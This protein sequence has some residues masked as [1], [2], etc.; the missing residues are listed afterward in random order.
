MYNKIIYHCTHTFKNK[1]WFA[2]LYLQQFIFY[3]KNCSTVVVKLKIKIQIKQIP[4]NG[5]Y[6]KYFIMFEFFLALDCSTKY[7]S[8]GWNLDEMS[9]TWKI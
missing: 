4:L 1:I 7:Q 2:N 8:G 6:F 3:V 9:Q 5:N